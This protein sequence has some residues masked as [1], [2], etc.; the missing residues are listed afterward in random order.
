MADDQLLVVPSEPA[1]SGP[2][3]GAITTFLAG[4][5]ARKV[6]E[7]RSSLARELDD[8]GP[9]ALAAL[10]AKLAG[11]GVD[12]HHYPRD[13]LATRIHEIIADRILSG[14][15]TLTGVEHVHAVADVPLVI[16][17]NHLSYS[18]ANVLEI[19]L[20][21]AGA[22]RVAERL[23][24]M[25]GP[26]VYSNLKRRFSSLC[27]GTIRIP[28]SAGVATEEAVMNPREAARQ[29]RRSIDVAH[30]RLR[31]GDVLLVFGEGTRSRSGGLQRMLPGVSRYLE[32]PDTWI[33]PVGLI[34][35]DTLFPIG[36][37]RLH[38]VRVTARAGP[39]IRAALLRERARRDR[40]LAMDC[41]GV[42]VADLLPNA[43]RGVY[44]QDSPDLDRARHLFHELSR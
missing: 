8:A 44:G 3:L 22:G 28:Q 9:A 38:P 1:G 31:A 25:A 13:P 21:R 37:D 29:A 35:T 26:K 18:D 4:Q 5:D 30:E 14:E 19:L 39:P 42:A 17:A 41:I 16:V 23:T 43:Y 20:Q 15:S 32:W 10:C 24:V 6:H 40:R 33:L 27:F 7:I 12:W 11:S 34:G 2:L 36:E